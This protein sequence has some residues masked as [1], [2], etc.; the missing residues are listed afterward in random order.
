MLRLL[1]LLLLSGAAQ[2]GVFS[3]LS[4]YGSGLRTKLNFYF[5]SATDPDPA[6][7]L[8]LASPPP[9][10]SIVL[11]EWTRAPRS[12]TTR[13]FVRVNL[14]A[15]RQKFTTAQTVKTYNRFVTTKSPWVRVN[16]N[17]NRPKIT[18]SR[19]NRNKVT[20]KSFQTTKNVYD[21]PYRNRIV[22]IT[23]PAPPRG[24]RV[25]IGAT[26]VDIKEGGSQVVYGAWTPEPSEEGE[27]SSTA[28]AAPPS[29]FD[30]VTS[31]ASVSTPAP[32]ATATTASFRATRES[33]TR[34]S[35]SLFE[36]SKLTETKVV[37]SPAAFRV[38]FTDKSESDE[39][40][41]IKTR[42]NLS[43]S[44]FDELLPATEEVKLAVGPAP[45]PPLTTVRPPSSLLLRPVSLFDTV[46]P[47]V[48]RPV[49]AA[50]PAPAPSYPLYWSLAG[51]DDRAVI[52]IPTQ[53]PPHFIYKGLGRADQQETLMNLTATHYG[54]ATEDRELKSRFGQSRPEV[55]L[56]TQEH[57]SEETPRSS[58][59]KSLLRLMRGDGK[60]S[61]ERKSLVHRSPEIPE[62]ST[63]VSP[64]ASPI[65][66]SKLS[67]KGATNNK[68]V[69]KGHRNQIP[70]K[71]AGIF[72]SDTGTVT[73]VS[74][75]KNEAILLSDAK[76]ADNIKASH[77]SL[78][79]DDNNPSQNMIQQKSLILQPDHNQLLN[80]RK[81]PEANGLLLKPLYYSQYLPSFQYY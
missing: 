7:D 9:G 21:S 36:V 20:N 4:S 24:R 26:G 19:T 11:G 65:F 38:K 25:E 40:L 54:Q 49:V 12:S 79:R 18:T 45:A 23:T 64:R 51:S 35:V 78:I 61:D 75:E 15:S 53:P 76:E 58:S 62:A 37:P 72:Y 71:T 13:P 59:K 44:L 48:S 33:A 32:P 16:L 17:Q 6:P 73:K 68:E 42:K 63:K 27:R 60:V 3:R 57:Q 14:D 1:A 10:R 52:K 28:A 30:L 5:S 43:E 46:Q 34:S 74:R 77:D 41:T 56:V 80:F 29:L 69:S 70:F 67:M 81:I 50:L 39:S 47:V 8:S 31:P 2:G 55:R 22:Y 66:I